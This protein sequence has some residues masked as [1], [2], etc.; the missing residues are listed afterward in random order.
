MLSALGTVAWVLGRRAL[1]L[2]LWELDNRLADVRAQA[3]LARLAFD[4]QWVF[5]RERRAGQWTDKRFSP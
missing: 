5:D 2:R 1:A 4:K 3:F